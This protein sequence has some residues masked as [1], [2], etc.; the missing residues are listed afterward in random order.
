MNEQRYKV[1]Q[2]NQANGKSVY[3]VADTQKMFDTPEEA[4]Y[5]RACLNAEWIKEQEPYSV[6]DSIDDC[7]LYKNGEFYAEFVNSSEAEQ[8]CKLLNAEHRKEQP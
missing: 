2:L 3:L 8:A 1:V 6:G 5:E 7:I 4:A